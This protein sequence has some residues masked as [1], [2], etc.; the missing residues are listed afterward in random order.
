MRWVVSWDDVGEIEP[1]SHFHKKTMLII[2]F[3][4]T[5]EYKI[6]ILPEG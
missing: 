6:L 3:N 1:S 5:G 4:G 2:F